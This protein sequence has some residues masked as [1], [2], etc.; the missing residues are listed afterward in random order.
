M[1]SRFLEEAAK[2]TGESTLNELAEQLKQCGDMWEEMA[3]PI[4]AALDVDHPERLLDG[5]PQK[6]NSIA[7]AE[8]RVFGELQKI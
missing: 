5:L 7:D 2:V 8:E 1:Y 3:A 4:K 6:L